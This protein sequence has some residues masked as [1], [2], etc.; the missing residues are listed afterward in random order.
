MF[1]NSDYFALPDEFIPERWTGDPRFASD[2]KEAFQ[3]FSV[4]ARNCIGKT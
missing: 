2:N 3:P 4:G 1:H